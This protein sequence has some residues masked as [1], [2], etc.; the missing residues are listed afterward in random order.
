MT[1]TLR[2]KGGT[3]E[4]IPY[5]GENVIMTYHG[6]KVIDPRHVMGSSSMS[7]PSPDDCIVQLEKAGYYTL[8][9]CVDAEDRQH[10]SVINK[11]ME[12]L[13]LLNIAVLDTKGVQ[14]YQRK[15]EEAFWT[16]IK[17]S[18]LGLALVSAL[19]LG[20]NM[21][22]GEFAVGWYYWFIPVVSGLLGTAVQ[23]KR[24]EWR[25]TEITGPAPPKAAI[26]P[27]VLLQRM[28]AILNTIG[29]Q[30]SQNI[31]F[32]VCYFV[33]TGDILEEKL[34]Q[35]AKEKKENDKKSDP[36]LMVKAGTSSFVIGVWGEETFVPEIHPC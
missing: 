14:K 8:A 11:L 27:T 4:L 22:V 2:T 30:N 15:I 13:Q 31:C 12:V 29:E 24:G 20:V 23:G 9:G 7:A 35:L 1:T 21:L 26:P 5:D 6:I 10:M 19:L 28:A 33:P 3:M 32:E 36:F 34:E 18:L 16:P 17:Y 25:T